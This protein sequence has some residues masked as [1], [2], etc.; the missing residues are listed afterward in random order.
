[1]YNN[2]VKFGR[3]NIALAYNCSNRNNKPDDPDNFGY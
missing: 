3:R 2:M 1:M